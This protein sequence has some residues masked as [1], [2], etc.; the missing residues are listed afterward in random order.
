MNLLRKSISTISSFLTYPFRRITRGIFYN[1]QTIKSIV[2]E[3][4][5]EIPTGKPNLITSKDINSDLGDMDISQE[6]I[7]RLER[8]FKHPE[9]EKKC[10][11]KIDLSMA[12]TPYDV[13]REAL[14]FYIQ[15]AYG[16]Y[17][18]IKVAEKYY[19]L[20]INTVNRLMNAFNGE[21]VF[22]I[23]KECVSTGKNYSDG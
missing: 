3:T 7:N 23:M 10:I 21:D 4:K 17:I 6:S 8:F 9:I 12:E 16:K 15:Y 1:P 2:L 22:E 11:I 13:L 18:L 20:N 14:N 5:E 19:T